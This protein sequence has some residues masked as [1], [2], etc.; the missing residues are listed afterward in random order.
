MDGQCG[1]FGRSVARIVDTG[2]PQITQI[3]KPE[4]TV[5]GNCTGSSLGARASRP[6]LSAKRERVSRLESSVRFA[7]GTPAVPVKSLNG[8]NDK[9]RNGK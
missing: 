2:Y 7:G 6:Q 3:R 5:T 1:L 8:F 4:K 9:M